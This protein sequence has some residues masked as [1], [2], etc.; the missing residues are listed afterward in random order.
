M[1]TSTKKLANLLE[2][3]FAFNFVLFV[4]VLPPADAAPAR[5]S[6]TTKTTNTNTVIDFST[7]L[8]HKALKVY[9]T[10]SFLGRG[11]LT[12]S[13]NGIRL[14]NVDKLRFILVAKAPDWKVT[15]FRHDDKTY[16][17]ENFSE[18]EDA[19]LFSSFVMMMPGMRLTTGGYSRSAF[20]FSGYDG[21][22]MTSSRTVLKYIPLRNM[23]IKLE[24]IIY[25]AYK[26]PTNAGL[27]VTYIQTHSGKDYT[28][29][30]SREGQRET[31]LDTSKIEIVAD[32]PKLF[33]APRGYKLAKSLVAVLG[34]TTVGKDSVEFQSL[35]DI[36]SRGGIK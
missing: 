24:S 26:T 19:G 23:P 22:L 35:F 34:G 33:E 4:L 9:Q 7:T 15:I 29:G 30:A 1:P 11:H 25:S 2:L 16:F 5:S 20:K 12:I 13:T 27:P 10:H 6:S 3:V 31:V 8:K 32:D 28:T 21:Y 14:E 17:A 18:F 36:N